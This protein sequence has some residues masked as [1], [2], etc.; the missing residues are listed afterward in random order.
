MASPWSPEGV[1]GRV[2]YE[3]RIKNRIYHSRYGSPDV[4][5]LPDCQSILTYDAWLF[6]VGQQQR[7]N[8]ITLSGTDQRRGFLQ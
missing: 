1:M 3:N 5:T 7:N 4:S 6:E 2:G 8:E